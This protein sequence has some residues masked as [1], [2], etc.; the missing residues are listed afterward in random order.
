MTALVQM[1]LWD[2]HMILDLSFPPPPKCFKFCHILVQMGHG[3][4][5]T[6]LMLKPILPNIRHQR[7]Q[8]PLCTSLTP[9]KLAQVHTRVSEKQAGVGVWWQLKKSEAV[10]GSL[11]S[12]QKTEVHF[13][14]R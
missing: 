4:T 10:L 1:C 3:A 14:H 9:L 13:W 11:G 6:S 2:L 12:S 5:I 8:I 7:G